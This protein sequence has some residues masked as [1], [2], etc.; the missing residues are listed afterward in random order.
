MSAIAVR[1][2]ASVRGVERVLNQL[3]NV[4]SKNRELREEAKNATSPMVATAS[5]QSGA[6]VHGA[7]EAFVPQHASK[8]H[9]IGGV[10]AIV[11]GTLS[12]SPEAVLFG[13]GLLAPLVAEYGRA[14]FVRQQP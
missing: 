14:L 3:A 9:L 11:Y 13:N 5:I 7:A 6:L 4:R 1:R 8:V 10:G 12:G 2:S